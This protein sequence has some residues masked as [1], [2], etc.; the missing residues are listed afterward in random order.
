MPGKD[1]VG[2][3]RLWWRD[4]AFWLGDVGVLS[5]FRGMGYGDLLVRLL[6]FKALSHGAHFLRL[7]T[8]E[9]A[10][11]FFARYGFCEEC[12]QGGRAVMGLAAADVRLDRCGAAASDAGFVP[13]TR[14][15]RACIPARS[16]RLRGPFFEI[17]SGAAGGS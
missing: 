5:D 14:R 17:P 6:L 10:V 8:P 3:A 7:E 1:P 9:E 12:R 15:A 13:R 16:A 4:G 11:A 2:A